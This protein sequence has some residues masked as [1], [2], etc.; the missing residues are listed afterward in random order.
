MQRTFLRLGLI[1]FLS[2]SPVLAIAAPIKA[3]ISHIEDGKPAKL[4]LAAG[5]KKGVAVGVTGFLAD[6]T[7]KKI[8]GT[9]FKVLSVEEKSCLVEVNVDASKIDGSSSAILNLP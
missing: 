5:S 8:E 3:F 1:A 7:G 2:F 9:D 4:K 6:S